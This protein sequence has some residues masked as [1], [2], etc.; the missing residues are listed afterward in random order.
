[1]PV[2]DAFSIAPYVRPVSRNACERDG[3]ARQTNK[4]N[5]GRTS[6]SAVYNPYYTGRPRT[7]LN[8]ASN[9][10][11]DRQEIIR[12]IKERDGPRQNV[13]EDLCSEIGVN[14]WNMLAEISL[15]GLLLRAGG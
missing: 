6:P 2:G 14:D 1:M 4:G 10:S 12:R 3:Y 8:T 11:M 13:S 9:E 7:P 15:S 5:E